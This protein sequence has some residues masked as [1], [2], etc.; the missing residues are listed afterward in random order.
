MKNKGK[1]QGSVYI[2]TSGWYYDHWE[3]VLYPPN[4]PKNKRFSIYSQIFNAVELNVTY[5][6]MPSESMIKSWYTKA[7]E[8]FIYTVKAYKE[9]THIRKLVNTDEILSRFLYAIS[10]LQNKLGMILFQLPPSLKQ[11]ISL[12][13]DFLELLPSKPHSCFEFRHPSWENDTTFDL[14]AR[15]GKSHVIVSKKNYPFAERHTGN[16]AYY[17]LHGP[18]QICASPYSCEFLE[19]LADHITELSNNGIPS[20][21]FF[22]NDIGGHAVR[23]AQ[24]LQKLVVER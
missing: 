11:D 23:N 15:F 12:L 18:E 21:S 2:G 19:M 9:I 20:F 16:I 7:P 4:L 24:S 3:E 10:P 14:L 5:Y 22:N 13:H 6:R 17:R 8:N 1:L